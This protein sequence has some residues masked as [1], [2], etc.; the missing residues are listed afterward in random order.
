MRL[1][2]KDDLLCQWALGQHLL[3]HWIVQEI[4]VGSN[5]R[6]MILELV[7]LDRLVGQECHSLFNKG[8]RSYL[9]LVGDQQISIGNTK[10][11]DNCPIENFEIK[12]LWRLLRHSSDS[13]KLDH[14]LAH[15]CRGWIA[16]RD[17][18]KVLFTHHLLKLGEVLD[19]YFGV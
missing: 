19:V 8:H 4:V 13:L 14:H 9:R 12:H 7:G 18:I 2:G 16:G 6:R 10:G 15:R 5:M 17:Q 1:Q 11:G 3:V